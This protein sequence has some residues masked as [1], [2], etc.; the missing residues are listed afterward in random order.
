[1]PPSKRPRQPVVTST[2]A[3]GQEGS[4][5]PAVVED[6]SVVPFSCSRCKTV[7]VARRIPS[8]GRPDLLTLA[9]HLETEG[10]CFAGVLLYNDAVTERTERGEIL[11]RQDEAMLSAFLESQQH[12]FFEKDSVGT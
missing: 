9:E 3:N 4:C 7:V 12:F 8:T 11:R 2:Q 1:M 5:S 10:R 6:D